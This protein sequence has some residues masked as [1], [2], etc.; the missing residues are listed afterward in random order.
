MDDRRLSDEMDT[1]VLASTLDHVDDERCSC[2]R[3]GDEPGLRPHRSYP[4]DQQYFGAPLD[5]ENGEYQLNPGRRRG[6]NSTRPGR[7][8]GTSTKAGCHKT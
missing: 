4:C 8:A 6:D 7:N 3:H 5:P 2:I 1:T